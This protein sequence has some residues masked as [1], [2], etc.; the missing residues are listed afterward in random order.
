MQTRNI[1][2][3]EE[4]FAVADENGKWFESN[5]GPYKTKAGA[6]RVA[7]YISDST[8]K[9]RV[10]KMVPIFFDVETNERITPLPE[11]MM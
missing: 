8:K 9:Y 1:H 3:A 2:Q 11:R 6:E 7:Q 10:V 4:F 5:A